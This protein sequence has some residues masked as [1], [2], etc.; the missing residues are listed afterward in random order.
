MYP[1][2]LLNILKG[3][4]FFQGKRVNGVRERDDVIKA[5]TKKQRRQA[6]EELRSEHEERARQVTDASLANV[7]YPKLTGFV[8]EAVLWCM[9]D[10][11]PIAFHFYFVGMIA[12][13]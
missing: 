11:T 1:N 2:R 7:K 8:K 3:L 4:G 9:V 6:N 13:Q 5:A 10:K 12:G